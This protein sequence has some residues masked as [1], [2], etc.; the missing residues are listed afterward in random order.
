MSTER[1]KAR[2]TFILDRNINGPGLVLVLSLVTGMILV[3][4]TAIVW[5]VSYVVSHY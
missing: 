5:A 3:I 1:N 4:G 2:G